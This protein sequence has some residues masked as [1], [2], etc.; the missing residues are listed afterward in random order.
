MKNKTTYETIS[1]ALSVFSQY[2]TMQDNDVNQYCR[3]CF[4]DNFK[5][6]NYKVF[7]D[8]AI[9]YNRVDSYKISIADST[10]I[11]CKVFKDTHNKT[12]KTKALEFSVNADNL[13]NTIYEIVAQ[14]LLQTDKALEY[15]YIERTQVKKRTTKKERNA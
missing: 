7:K 8:F 12:D 14:R 3:I 1:N 13:V 2:F 15:N 9:Y 10:L 4:T 5:K 11:D 6:D